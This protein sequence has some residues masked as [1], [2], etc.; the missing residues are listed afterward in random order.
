MS[1]TRKSPKAVKAETSKAVKAETPKAEKAVKAEPR[2]RATEAA[3]VR[4]RAS[5]VGAV[6]ARALGDGATLTEAVERI[7]AGDFAP[8][9]SEAARRDPVAYYRGYLSY[10]VREELAEPVA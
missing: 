5:S 4:L 6:L 3:A 7:A 9:R 1:D 8:P 10:L 2:Y